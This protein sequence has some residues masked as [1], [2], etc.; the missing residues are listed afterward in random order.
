M[1]KEDE[2]IEMIKKINKINDVPCISKSLN[3]FLN[4]NEEKQRLFIEK[5]KNLIKDHEY[6]ILNFYN[7]K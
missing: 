3:N 7:K 4:L 2:L 6:L 5:I 1:T